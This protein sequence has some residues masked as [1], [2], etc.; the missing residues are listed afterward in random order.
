MVLVNQGTG[1]DEDGWADV[2][3][4]IR[5]LA[6][7]LEGGSN[8]LN[9]DSQSANQDAQDEAPSA[10]LNSDDVISIIDSNRVEYGCQ[11]ARGG[12]NQVVA[13]GTTVV[14]GFNT[15]SNDGWTYE[16]A[17]NCAAGFNT[18][19]SVFTAPVTGIYAFTY[20]V[21]TGGGTI[22]LPIAVFFVL[23]TNTT[24]DSISLLGTAGQTFAG[25]ATARLI[26]GDT[27][28]I[29]YTHLGT[30]TTLGTGYTYFAASLIADI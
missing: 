7:L 4:D 8:D 19:T 23:N 2:I 24:G 9:F 15:I 5:R 10:G 29:E 28:W 12:S 14:V 27:V 20:Q 22:G 13:S 21:Y 6:L 11:V 3:S 16:Q 18:A 26:A 25:S 30:A 17:K 1:F